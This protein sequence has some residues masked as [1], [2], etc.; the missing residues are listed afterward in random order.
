MRVTKRKK[1]AVMTEY[2]RVKGGISIL[3]GSLCRNCFDGDDDGIN[4]LQKREEDL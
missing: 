4:D 2:F 3:F 1:M